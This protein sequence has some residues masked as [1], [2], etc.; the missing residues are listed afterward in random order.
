MLK[1]ST[2]NSV[3]RRS[4]KD[5]LL[6]KKPDKIVPKSLISDFDSLEDVT[7][8]SQRSSIP[9][10]TFEVYSESIEKTETIQYSANSS[11]LYGSTPESAQISETFENSPVSMVDSTVTVSDLPDSNPH[12]DIVVDG[13]NDEDKRGI[14]T[15]AGSLTGDLEV[16]LIVDLLQQARLQISNA[17]SVDHPYKK[18]I[19]AVIKTVVE[20]C[21]GSSQG[22]KSQSGLELVWLKVRIGL[23]CCFMWIILV[24]VILRYKSGPE[25]YYLGTPPT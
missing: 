7:P 19:D 13:V 10:E 11:E 14:V 24:L 3:N 6:K 15:S 16:Q 21:Y 4:K 17:A 22:E 8:E 20:D 12:L 18:I 9:S 25:T 1:V 2:Q 5:S 23:F